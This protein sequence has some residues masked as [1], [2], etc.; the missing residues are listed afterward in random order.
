MND[1]LIFGLLF[2]GIATGWLL[3]RRGALEAVIETQPPSQYYQGLNYL[4]DGRHDGA[5]DSFIND[6]EINSETLDTHI[7]L[8]N[9]LRK[10][11]DVDR[12][13]RIHQNLL[14]GSELPNSQLH[15]A[16]LELAR[17]YI[18][19]G[20]LDRAE[21]LLIDLTGESP[22]QHRV[23]LRHLL[24]IYHSE[25]DWPRAIEVAG[26]LARLESANDADKSRQPATLV[27]AHYHCELALEK[28][29]AG[30]TDAA[31][32]LLRRTLAA[33]PGCARASLMLGDLEIEA[34]RYAAAEKILRNVK[35]QDP[36]Y[37]P[38]TIGPL[39]RCYGELGHEG[40][41]K[42]WLQECMAEHPSAPL[43]LAIA[44]D[45]QRNDGAASA[46]DFLA[47]QLAQHPSIRGIAQLISLQVGGTDGKAKADLEL[48]QALVE[49]LIAERPAYRCSHCGFSGQRLH[50]CCPGCQYW[51][52]VKG[53]CGAPID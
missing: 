49:R 32:H 38:E 2:V 20:L 10:R 30:D 46:G 27:L 23:S 26:E 19:A 37:V 9:L 21:Q 36:G 41:L 15:Q 3:G 5:M 40:R 12:A 1:L 25:R 17:D 42:P 18:S 4:L 35:R 16:H 14:A 52:T 22:A 28:Q 45:M 44:E 11:G 29:A 8:G 6:L 33:D 51:G 48:L 50:W 39:R 43:V 47:A 13:I 34:G 53:I 31:R 7:A 24:D